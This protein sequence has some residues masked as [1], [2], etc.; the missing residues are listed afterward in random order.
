LP[1][2][3][4]DP[5]SYNWYAEDRL[6]D[7]PELSP[8]PGDYKEE[9]K[10]GLQT[11]T[12]RLEF[13]SSSLKR[14]D[15]D[16]P[17]RPPIMTWR[18]SW[19]GPHTAELIENYPLQL[20]TPHP[21]FSFH[22]H[23]DGKGGALNDVADHRIEIDGY[24]YWIARISPMDAEKRGIKQ[25]EVIRLFNDRGGVLCAAVITERVR[26]GLVHSYESSAVYDPTGAPGYSD[27]RGGCVNLLT[28]SR[29]QIKR[30]HATAANSCLIQVE[31]VRPHVEHAD[32]IA[33]KRAAGPE[34][35]GAGV[36]RA[37]VPAA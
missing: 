8:L 27:D 34:A 14:F 20:V 1:A 10:R 5:V 33:V 12:G 31:R 24:H 30:S 2:E 32:H 22:T 29:M 9:W 7:V 26:P 3:N 6:K 17:E 25:H 23:H 19:E 16:D 11:Q 15:P 21:R 13:E 4:R 37:A 35:V 28:P 18:E 36:D